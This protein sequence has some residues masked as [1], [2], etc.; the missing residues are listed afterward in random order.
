MSA[1]LSYKY[2]PILSSGGGVR[3]NLESWNSTSPINGSIFRSDSS[4]SMIYN[5]AHSSQFLRTVMSFFT[6]KIVP[7][8]ANGQPI[9]D[10]AT[11]NSSLGAMAAWGRL[12]IRFGS[13]VV[14]DIQSYADLLA[15]YYATASKS[16][17][18]LLRKLEGYG[19]TEAFKL[20][21]QKYA[22][23]LMSSLWVTDQ[24][25]PIPLVANGGV[26]IEVFLN[27]ASTVFTSA[28]VAYYQIESPTFKWMGISPNPSY[29]MGLRSAVASGRSVYI[30]F[31]KI[32]QF[33]SNGN[34]SNTQIIN[35][36]VGQVSSIVS[37]DTV[38]WDDAGYADRSKD[39]FKR[40]IDPGV[41]EYR[42][43]GAGLSNPSQLTFHHEGGADPE[44]FLVGQ[45]GQVGNAY[46]LD[47]DISYEDDFMNTT[48]KISQGYLSDNEHFGTGLNTLA[49]ASPFL[50][51]T[52]NCDR[53]V[54]TTTKIMSFVTTD[55]LL[56]FRGADVAYTE[57][58]Q[59]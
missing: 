1:V 33:P 51:L 19:N 3:A 17:K 13:L 43:E 12:V 55:A 45:L 21:G 44:L 25:I 48:F 58:F 18:N 2:P 6:G 5:V 7:Y 24:A 32:H 11:R 53:V 47:K 36:G 26:S 54:P 22:H 23:L 16:K 59:S 37:V 52:V 8:G 4:T 9:V 57:I 31:Q 35:I 40:F 28:N 46:A 27:P 38:F 30:P 56:E 41:V 50:T 14:E 49:A 15:L 42:I 10:A 29:V 39:K 20:G 34:G